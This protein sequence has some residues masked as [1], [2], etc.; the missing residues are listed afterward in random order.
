MSELYILAEELT[1]TSSAFIGGQNDGGQLNMYTKNGGSNDINFV[2]TQDDSNIMFNT[3]QLYLKKDGANVGNVGIGKDKP[4]TKLDILGDMS[5][6]GDL[7]ITGQVE[8]SG[9]K[10][11]I[12]MTL[13]CHTKKY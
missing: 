11:L 12:F 8:I 2:A 6:N 7:D 10:N 13:Q 1:V 3:D 4:E 9:N 5:L